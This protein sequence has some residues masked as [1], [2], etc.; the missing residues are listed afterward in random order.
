[1]ARILAVDEDPSERWTIER[2]LRG[3]GHE[4]VQAS[5]VDEA[6]RLAGDRTFDVALVDYE[7]HNQQGISVLQRLREVQPACLRVL[8]TGNL[9]SGT[10]VDAVNR[11]EVTRLISKPLDPSRLI[12]AVD[13]VL[14]SRRRLVEVARVQEA[15]ASEQER[16]MLD[17]CLKGD[18]LQLAIQPILRVSKDSSSEPDLFAY[19]CLLRSTHSVL[20]GPLPVLKAA[21]RHGML[22]DLA[23][24]VVKRAVHWMEKLPPEI[25]L[26][27]NLHPDELGDPDGMLERLQPLVPWAKRVVLEITERSRLQGLDS[28]ERAVKQVTNLGFST[29]VDDLGAGYSSLSV[30]AELQ[31]SFV[32]V[33]MSIVRGVDRD[34]RKQRLIDLLCRFA[35]ATDAK[36]VAEGVE[37][38]AESAVLEECGAD[39]LQGYLYGRP[40]FEMLP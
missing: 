25:M 29:A 19:E 31:P 4:V 5:I 2:I 12:D 23:A 15:V 38:E 20:S 33:D 7:V 27:M 21:E 18:D 28:W 36:L 39:F 3:E 16:L 11:G 37:T 9:E 14:S 1:M 6:V 8:V 40:S 13:Q 17:E 24:V 32:K 30:L 10:V 26:F 35:E 22:S 34:E